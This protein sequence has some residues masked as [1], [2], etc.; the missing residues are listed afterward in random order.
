MNVISIKIPY[1]RINDFVHLTS[2]FDSDIDL[3]S[4]HNM[5]DAKSML[6]VHSLD[7]NKIVKLKIHNKT[8]EEL[9][10]FENEFKQ[11]TI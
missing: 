2:S 1:D 9:I 11:F 5:I 7:V 4:G 3:I 6:G 8:K 10:R